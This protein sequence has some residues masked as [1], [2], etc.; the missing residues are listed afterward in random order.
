MEATAPLARHGP[1]DAEAMAMARQRATTLVLLS[2]NG[3]LGHSAHLCG[4]LGQRS[5]VRGAEAYF[6]SPIA[7]PGK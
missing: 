4:R 1:Q 3:R 6:K 2:G 5:R 7:S